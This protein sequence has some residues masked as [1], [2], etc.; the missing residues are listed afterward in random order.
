MQRRFVFQVLLLFPALD[1]VERRLG[2]VEMPPFDQLVHL[3]EK[4]GEKQRKDVRTVNVRIGH[5]DD[6]VIAEFGHIEII[7]ADSGT[8]GGYERPDLL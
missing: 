5:D 1:L 6:P 8:Q 7:L 3:A 2:Y 4:E